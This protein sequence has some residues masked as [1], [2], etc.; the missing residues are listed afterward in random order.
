MI[1]EATCK[2]CGQLLEVA[3]DPLRSPTSGFPIVFVEPC[4]TCLSKAE[5]QGFRNGLDS[6][7][8]DE[9]KDW[10]DD[11]WDDGWDTAEG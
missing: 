1:C 5:N 10:E 3:E 4:P 8:E 6:N 11:D 2:V 7:W 9:D